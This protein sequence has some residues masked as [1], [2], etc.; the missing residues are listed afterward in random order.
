MHFHF[1]ALKAKSNPQLSFHQLLALDRLWQERSD[2]VKGSPID[3]QIDVQYM[4]GMVVAK[5]NLHCDIQLRCAK[6]LTNFQQTF[7]IPFY[8]MFFQP[9]EDM[10]IEEDDNIHEISEDVVEL[11]PFIEEN[12]SLSIPNVPHCSS[13]CK[14]LCPECGV[15]R[16]NTSCDCSTEKID[17]RFAALSSL[18]KKDT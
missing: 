8:E 3:C 4:G 14:G 7:K 1:R 5:G 12:V 11:A 6:C 17:S 2:V 10:E 16:N 15:D 18:F 9:S 13:T